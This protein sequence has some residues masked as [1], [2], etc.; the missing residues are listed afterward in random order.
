MTEMAAS[1]TAKI[2]DAS[3][4]SVTY[5]VFKGDQK[6]VADQTSLGHL[7][8]TGMLEQLEW[9]RISVF[10]KIALQLA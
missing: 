5:L 9:P 2:P 8:V 10:F 6:H 4:G 7:N 1:I 3:S